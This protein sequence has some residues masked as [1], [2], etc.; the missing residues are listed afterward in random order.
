MSL[1]FPSR[2]IT[3]DA[4]LRDLAKGRP[5][6]RVTAAQRARRRRPPP[7]AAASDRA[8]IAALEDND[9][10]VRA[11]AAAS[12]GEAGARER[13]ARRG[14]RGGADP[15]PR[16][17]SRRGPPGR[18]HRARHARPPAGFAPLATALA[19]AA[20]AISGTRPPPRSPRSM[21]VAAFTRLAAALGDP[22][23]PRWWRRWRSSLGAHRRSARPA[24]IARLLDHADAGVRFD[25]AY[26]LAAARRSS[27]RARPGRRPRRQRPRLGCRP[28]RSSGSATP[29]GAALAGRARPPRRPT[30]RS[31][32]APPAPPSPSPPDGPDA[33]RAPRRTCSRPSPRA[34]V[35]VRGLAVEELATGRRRLGDRAAR[36]PSPPAA[37][38]RSV[39]DAIAAALRRIATERTVSRPDRALRQPRPRRRPRVRR[40]PRRGP[41]ARPRRRGAAHGRD[42]RGRRSGERRARGRPRRARPRHL[43]HRRDPPARRRAR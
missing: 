37:R 2:T 7:T 16:R 35:T 31:R 15:P 14:R 12:L 28:P 10:E 18:R 20:R 26:A 42:R 24:L 13:S 19:R 1:L 40:R 21:P 29:T 33:A 11:E 5:A 30:P 32:S 23:P 39:A 22:D 17:R 6:A 25:V 36:A 38:A 8:L 41:R 43:G 3:I 34:A 9:P 27:R 4:A